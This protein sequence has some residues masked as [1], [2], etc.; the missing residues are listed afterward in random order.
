MVVSEINWLIR[1]LLNPLRIMS[2]N[3]FLR[4]S[5]MTLK[6]L[7]NWSENFDPQL[8]CIPIQP[9]LISLKIHFSSQECFDELV[10]RLRTAL[11]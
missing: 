9:I 10:G 2:L 3:Y 11:F 1:K 8:F 6:L 5:R 7:K 4:K